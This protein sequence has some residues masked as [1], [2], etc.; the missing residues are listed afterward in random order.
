MPWHTGL[1]PPLS[2]PVAATEGEP[3][4]DCRRSQRN[5]PGGVDGPRSWLG[6]TGAPRPAFIH[7]AHNDAYAAARRLWQQHGSPVIAAALG[8]FS[9]VLSAAPEMILRSISRL[10]PCTRRAA[11]TAG[12]P[13]CCRRAPLMM[14][15][16][17]CRRGPYPVARGRTVGSEICPAVAG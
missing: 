14:T 15:L 1:R 7:I 16:A 5:M 2:R 10:S 17:E 11:P 8:C 9:L 13:P 12:G 6:F 4:G 3:H